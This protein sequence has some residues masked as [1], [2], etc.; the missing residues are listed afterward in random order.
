MHGNHSNV[1]VQSDS[2]LSKITHATAFI[3]HLAFC[4][5]LYFEE[6]PSFI[7]PLCVWIVENYERIGFAWSVDKGL[8]IAAAMISGITI[9]IARRIVEG[10][11]L[12]WPRFL[13]HTQHTSRYALMRGII[14]V[15]FVIA[16]LGAFG[17]LNTSKLDGSLFGLFYVAF[18]TYVFGLVINVLDDAISALLTKKEILR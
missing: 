6:L 16:A 11:I 7:R 17:A 13:D 1:V 4:A 12:G 9:N 14:Y 8:I 3:V 2:R 15:C 10:M 18:G 5:F